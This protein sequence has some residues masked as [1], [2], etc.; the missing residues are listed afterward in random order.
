MS[1]QQTTRRGNKKYTMDEIVRSEGWKIFMDR[2]HVGIA[3]LLGVSLLI[4]G[5]ERK[6]DERSTYILSLTLSTLATT[7]FFIGYEKFESRSKILSYLFYRV[8]GYGLTLGFVTLLFILQH[9]PWPK[10]IMLMLSV[11]MILTSLILGIQEIMGE[12]RNKIGWLYFVRILMALAP[13]IYL[14]LKKPW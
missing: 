2:L 7:C 14:A 4:I 9:W 3:I 12:N 11:S 1:D 10:E 8:Y 6:L 13:L 5:I